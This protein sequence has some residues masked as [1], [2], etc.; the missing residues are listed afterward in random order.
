MRY[1][2][3]DLAISATGIDHEYLLVAHSTT[4]GEATGRAR[5][6][7]AAPPLSTLLQ[8]PAASNQQSVQLG[9]L[10]YQSLFVDQ[11]AL[12]FQR[13]LGECLRDDHIGLRIRLRIEAA[14]LAALPWEYLY[15]PQRRLFLAASVET[16]VSRYLNLTEPVR[17]LAGPEKI[18]LLAVIPQ[19]SGL[20]IETEREMLAALA[21]RLSGKIAVDILAGEATQKALRAAL[22][23][24]DYH[25]FH[26]AGHGSFK[27]DEAFIHLD[28]SEKLTEPMNADQFA[29][30]FLDYPSMRLVFLN[31][32]QGA[33]RSSHQALTGLAPQLVLRGVPAVIAMQDSIANDDAVLFATEFYA[34]LCD[35]RD[36]GQVEVAISRARKVLLQEKPQSAGF[37]NPAL[38]LRAEEGR[39]WEAQSEVTIA[40]LP[41]PTKEENSLLANLGRAVL[42]E[43]SGKVKE[44]WLSDRMWRTLKGQIT[45]ENKHPLSGVVVVLPEFGVKT[46]TDEIGAFH[47]ELMKTSAQGWIN[48]QASKEGYAPLDKTI[49]RFEQKHFNRL[50]MKKL[51]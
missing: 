22:R 26:Y 25:I 24:H 11:I 23:Q 9:T 39:L 40:A 1:H 42:G 32:C 19:N 38:Y 8:Q 6:N 7:A 27:N 10:L 4:Q 37:G 41:L 12:L 33:A 29:Q 3:F 48:L 28:H 13:A 14:E 34:E 36:G 30:F 49:L 35:A 16:P 45:D 21:G 18:N 5:I 51:P 44:F 15:D 47:F 31:A 2:T 43:L 17:K 20:E 46:T 50:K